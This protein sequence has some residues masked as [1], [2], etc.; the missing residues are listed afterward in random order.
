MEDG[1]LIDK[2]YQQPT[3]NQKHKIM[4]EEARRVFEKLT[5]LSDD[6]AQGM[7]VSIDQLKKN[8]TQPVSVPKETHN[9]SE[10]EKENKNE[11]SAKEAE[12]PIDSYK[13]TLKENNISESEAIEILMGVYYKGSYTRKYKIMGK[14]IV[15]QIPPPQYSDIKFSILNEMS[16]IYKQHE[17][18]INTELN[19]AAALKEFD[20]EVF[21]DTPP[22]Q[23]LLE[24]FN[25]IRS[26][27][28]YVKASI[29]KKFI[30]F[31]TK[32]FIVTQTEGADDFF[33]IARSQNT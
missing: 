28:E 15:F 33:E 6:S 3:E 20:G 22:R 32:I 10:Q 16:P 17:V 9:N 12:K 8:D 11:D 2:I 19:V 30:D 25:F 14:P 21:S 18:A 7:R 13:R 27:N 4:P 31:E 29:F 23:S 5:S 24:K 26:L 1:K